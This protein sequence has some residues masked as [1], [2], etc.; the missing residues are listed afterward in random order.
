MYVNIYVHRYKR[1]LCAEK[2]QKK[3]VLRFAQDDKF[4]LV[5]AF[6]FKKKRVSAGAGEIGR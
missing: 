5:T 6:Y 2:K 3:Q 1:P 4:N